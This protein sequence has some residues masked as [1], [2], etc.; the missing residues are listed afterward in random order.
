MIV[1]N[2]STITRARHPSGGLEDKLESKIKGKVALI[3]GGASG[4]GLACA[5]LFAREGASVMI[6]DIDEAAG[7]SALAGLVE[8]GAEAAFVAADVADSTSV[9][10]MVGA[11]VARF[12]G[13]DV[14]VNSAGVG[15]AARHL[16]L[17]DEA[18]FDRTLAINLR[19]VFLGMKYAIPVML[20]RG[21]SIVNIASVGGMRSMPMSCDY[22]AS[23]AGVI[24]LTRS[25]AREYA[26]HRIRVNAVC[27]GWTDT[28]MVGE[29]LR[30]EGEPFREVI[31]N[32]VPLHRLGTPEEVAQVVLFLAAVATFATGSTFVSDGG[33][34]A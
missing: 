33:T 16:H 19:G 4:I 30:R 15:G 25:A 9:Q 27:P 29:V 11:T 13:L 18:Q 23:K 3:T 22:A 6:A 26:S 10:A 20:E 21:G 7:Q 28:P 32:S 31:L 1:G 8:G 17:M 5:R 24:S 34:I 12:G 14:L 2:S